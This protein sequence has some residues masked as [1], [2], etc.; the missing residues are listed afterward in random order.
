MIEVQ[1][2]PESDGEEEQDEEGEEGEEDE[3]GEEGQDEENVALREQDEPAPFDEE[4]F[5][6]QMSDRLEAIRLNKALGNDDD[7]DDADSHSDSSQSD[8]DSDDVLSDAPP[9][10]DFTAYVRAPPTRPARIDARKLGS[11]NELRDTVARQAV[12][13]S[14]EKDKKH[15]SRKGAKAGNAKGHKWKTNASNIVAKAGGDGW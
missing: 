5:Q 8:S 12:R 13:Q 10:S 4:A 15:H 11:G 3:E 2:L 9:Q 6:K 1:D 7:E 14:Q